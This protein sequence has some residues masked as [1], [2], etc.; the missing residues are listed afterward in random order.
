MKSLVRGKRGALSLRALVDAY[1]AEL[2]M[3]A[4]PS[5]LK[6]AKS[7]LEIV[8]REIGDVPAD[9]LDR[10]ALEDWRRARSAQGRS[11]RTIN[12]DLTT[13]GA[14]FAFALDRGLVKENPVRK[15][16]RLPQNGR[17][18]RRI[19][20]A[21]GDDEIRKLLAAGEVI[22]A[23]FPARFPRTPL[24]RVLFE[25]GCRWYE[26]VACQWGDFDSRHGA[27]TLRGDNTKTGQTRVV[28]LRE[29]TIAVIVSLRAA[30][31]RVRGDLPTLADRIFLRPRGSKWTHD[32][33]G[34]HLFLH[35]CL[36]VAKVPKADAASR[37]L[38]RPRN[39]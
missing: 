21:A 32:T 1:L 3:R 2:A 22:D 27:L 38:P 30:H 17:H 33:S 36:R 5:T 10:L 14:A 19:A 20:R 25:T 23:R 26:L 28:P 11:N 37:I 39:A 31:V 29:D 8:L 35:E 4:K 16:R 34:Y 15:L 18:R 9:S 6:V 24:L 7:A 13:L 12:R